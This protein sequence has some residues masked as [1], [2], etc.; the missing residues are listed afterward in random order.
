MR[1]V[2]AALILVL[3][4]A[5][6]AARPRDGAASSADSTSAQSSSKF[7]DPTDGWFDVSSFLDTG[8]GFVPVVAPVTEPAVGYGAGGGLVFVKRNPPLPDGGYRRPNMTLLGGMLTENGT[9]LTAVGHS[10]SWRE[11]AL[12]TLVAGVYGVIHLDF[13]GIGGGPLQ[14]NPLRYELEPIGGVAQARHRLGQSRFQ[15]GLAYD[16]ASINVTFDG[17][18]VPDEIAPDE[19]ETRVG[20]LVP[21]LVFDSRDNFFTPTRGILSELDVAAFSELLGGTT[22]FQTVTALG[23]FYLPAGHSVFL[24]LMGQ[25]SFS[26][27]DVPFYMRPYIS[28][29]GAPMMRYMG[30][31][32][33]SAEL[34]ARWQ[35]WRRVSA[36]GFVGTGIAWVKTD[37]F[38]R[39]QSIVTGGGG[40]RYELAR[41]Y[42]LHM[43]F[44][45]GWG[46]DETALY[47]QF[48][49]A[50]IR[51]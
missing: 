16:L 11:D 5:T 15:V 27:G 39:D 21:A 43:G 13:Y 38:E 51:P 3:S 35:F 46:P 28:L 8:H 41:R 7:F 40:M 34:E 26:F 50:W 25:A 45:V 2:V 31:N 20:G 9:W 24:G 44:D 18:L 23:L 33:A 42:G 49:S 47:I 1:P 32:A 14:D 4:A 37:R 6:G 10:G 12:Q 19:L 22:D 29:R 48:G 36:V 30:E 17:D